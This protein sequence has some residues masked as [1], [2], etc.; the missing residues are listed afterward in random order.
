MEG[1]ERGRGRGEGEGGG[2]RREWSPGLCIQIIHCVH[3]ESESSI[4]LPSFRKFLKISKFRFY[5]MK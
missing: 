5:I 1:G 2:G 4:C 3:I